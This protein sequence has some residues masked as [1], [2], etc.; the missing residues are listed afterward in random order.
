M[1][2]SRLKFTFHSPRSSFLLTDH[3]RIFCP[4]RNV[5]KSKSYFLK[6][7]CKF[8]AST[9]EVF[10][11]NR[12]AFIYWTQSLHRQQRLRNSIRLVF[13]LL[14]AGSD[15]CA[16]LGWVTI[17]PMTADQ[18]WWSFVRTRL[19]WSPLKAFLDFKLVPT[20]GHGIHFEQIFFRTRSLKKN[21]YLPFLNPFKLFL[22][23]CW[24]KWSWWFVK[25]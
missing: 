15:H 4:R 6:R 11:S 22:G 19:S 17:G 2:F 3:F 9:P 7:N 16:A 20:T 25:L 14:F 12:V 18:S 24:W 21:L 23:P 5:P 8:I 1:H 10:Q 13:V